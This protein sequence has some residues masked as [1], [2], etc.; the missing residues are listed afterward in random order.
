MKSSSL[1][2]AHGKCTATGRHLA[3]F[4]MSCLVFNTGI[5]CTYWQTVD[6]RFDEK[7]GKM[8]Y[9]PL[10]KEGDLVRITDANSD[11][12]VLSASP[13]MDLSNAK[14]IEI[15]KGG[16]SGL[17]I[18]G[19]ILILGVVAVCVGGVLLI[20]WLFFEMGRSHTYD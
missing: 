2:R 6:I 12:R 3:F 11:A 7:L 17:V 13:G 19:G 16:M 18:V 9:S 8:V 20:V 4:L 5:A 1:F 15:R 14:K 10:I